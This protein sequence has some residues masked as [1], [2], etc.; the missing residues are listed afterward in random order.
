MSLKKIH[1]DEND[2]ENIKFETLEKGHF[3]NHCIRNSVISEAEQELINYDDSNTICCGLKRNLLIKRMLLPLFP[4]GITVLFLYHDI[5][6]SF[7]LFPMIVFGCSF[8]LFMNFPILVVHSNLKPTYFGQDLFIDTDK[9]PYLALTLDEKKQFLKNLKWLLILLYS[10][11][12]AALSDYWLFKTQNSSSF[13][14]VLGVTGGILKIFQLVATIGGG[15]FL[16]KTRKS[17][18]KRSRKNSEED[19]SIELMEIH[20]KQPQDNIIIDEQ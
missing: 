3:R 6:R 15:F 13:F 2:N 1:I 4:G 20:L 10:A 16:N 12:S 9:L 14:E 8:V 19:S 11:L 7:Y 5:R 17:A 18:L